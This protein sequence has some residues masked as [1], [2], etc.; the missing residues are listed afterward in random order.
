M[1]KP[2]AGKAWINEQHKPIID[3]RRVSGTKII[4]GPDGKDRK[5][6][7]LVSVTTRQGQ[8]IRIPISDVKQFP[9]HWDDEKGI[10]DGPKAKVE[11]SMEMVKRLSRNKRQ[12]KKK[13]LSFMGEKTENEGKPKLT[14]M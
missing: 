2:K 9:E 11:T 4:K 6:G 14:F 8:V 1:T 5:V 3:C 7:N 13:Q 12:R 10:V